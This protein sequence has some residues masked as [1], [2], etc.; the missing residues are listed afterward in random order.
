MDTVKTYP[1][2]EAQRSTD[3]WNPIW[4]QLFEMDPDYLEAFLHFRSVPQTNGPLEKKYKEMV[5]MASHAATTHLHVTVVRR[6]INNPLRASAHQATTTKMITTIKGQN[7]D[8]PPT[9]E[10]PIHYETPPPP[11][12]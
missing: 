3:D 1:H 9:A 7:A 11:D 6:H 2:I 10:S 4:D 12:H 5:V 8:P